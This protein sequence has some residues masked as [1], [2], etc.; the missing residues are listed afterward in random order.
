MGD[1]RNFGFYTGKWDATRAKDIEH[2]NKFTPFHDHKEMVMRGSGGHIDMFSSR[3]LFMRWKEQFFVNVSTE[4]GLT[5]AG[6]Y[7][8]CFDRQ[9]GN[10]EGYYHDANSSP[11]Q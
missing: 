7:Y 5:I 3:Y 6:F 4:C 9:Q 1:N 10:I 8:V 11:W 2:W